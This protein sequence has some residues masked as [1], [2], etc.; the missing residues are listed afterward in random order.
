MAAFMYRLGE[1]EGTE[2]RQEVVK[3]DGH[4]WNLKR[5]RV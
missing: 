1:K 5:V 4:A 2:K 3:R